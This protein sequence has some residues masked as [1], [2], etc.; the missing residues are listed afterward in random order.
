MSQSE[1]PRPP[2]PPFDERGRTVEK[3]AQLGS[4]LC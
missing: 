1:Q 4:Y 3:V 2:F